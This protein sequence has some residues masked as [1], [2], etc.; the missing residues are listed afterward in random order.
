MRKT[1]LRLLMTVIAVVGF[2]F[3]GNAQYFTETFENGGTFPA[4]WTLTNG[5]DDWDIDQGDDY[6]PGAAQ[7]GTYCAFFNDYDYSSGTEAEMISPNIDLSTATAPL[8]K[9]W[10]WDDGGSDVVEVLASSDGSTYST[11]YTTDETVSDWTEITV[12][13]SAYAGQATVTISFKGT[14]VYGMTNPH[15]DNIIID[16]APSCPNPSAQA[17]SDILTT[18][19]TLSWTSGDAESA[20]NVEY[21]AIGFTQGT[22]TTVAVTDT[23][24]NI[25]GLTAQ[26][27][28]DFYVQADCGGS[29]VSTWVGPYTFTTLCDAYTATFS[30][31]FDGVTTPDL[32]ACWNSLI[33][34]PSTTYSS[35]T[36]STTQSSSADNSIKLY[37]SSATSS[38]NILLITPNFSD[39]TSQSNRIKFKAHMDGSGLE[40][41]TMTDL[42]DEST[43]TSYQTIAENAGVWTEYTIDFDGNY[44]DN[45]NYIVFRHSCENTYDNIYIDD[46]VYEP[47]PSCLEPSAQA[48]S[49]ILTTSA[50]LS[51][52]S[53]DAESAW[54]VEYGAAGYT[55]GTGTTVA[56][57][58]TFINITGLTAQTDYDFYVQADCGGDVSVWVGPYSFS[59]LCDVVSTFQYTEDF[60]DTSIP[61]CWDETRTPSSSYGWDSYTGGYDANCFRFDSYFNSNG[62]ISLLNTVTFDFSAETSLELKFW[63]KNPSGGNFKVVLSTDGGSTY[64]VTLADN[65]TG[66]SDY[67][68]KIIDLTAYC[69]GTNNNI[70]IGF[71][72]TSNY[73]SGDAYIYLDK[74][75]IS[76][77][78]TCPAP[79]AQDAIN[80]DG[81]SADLQWITGGS[82]LWNIVYG[83]Q[84]FDMNDS[85]VINV[86]DTIY[87]VSGLEPTTSYDFYVQD[88]CGL[89]DVSVWV[90]PYTFTTTVSCPAPTGLTATSITN[91][92]A[93]VSWITG[94]S[95]LWNIVY[96]PQGFDMNDSTAISV[97]DTFYNI[98]GL[99]PGTN[100]DFYVQDSCGVVDVSDWTG[101]YT[102]NTECDVVTTFPWIED[103]EENADELPICFN[104]VEGTWAMSTESYSGTY[105]ARIT[106]NHSNPAHLESPD[107]IL[108]ANHKIS[109][110][111][112]DD[113]V[114]LAKVIGHDTTF[115]EISTD[116]GANWI[117]LDT[118]SASSNESNYNMAEHDLSAYAGTFKFRFRDVSDAS[119]SA[120]GTGV[121]SIVI[122]ENDIIDLALIMPG[123]EDYSDCSFTGQ[124]TIP[125]FVEN[126]G[127]I[128]IAATDTIFAWYELD[129]AA[130]V[131]DTFIIATDINP[132]DTMF[133]FFAQTADL[134]GLTTHNFKVYFEYEPGTDMD[135]VN[136]T[137]VGTVTHY[138]LTVD[139]GGVNDTISTNSYPYTLDAGANLESYLWND[140]SMN[141][142]L[143]VNADGWYDV[144]VTDTNGCEAFD[145]VYVQLTIGINTID[146]ISLNIYPNP[147]NGEFTLNANFNTAIDFT[148]DIIN[149]NGKTIYSKEFNGVDTINESIDIDEYSKGVYYVRIVN[150]NFVKQEKVIVY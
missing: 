141:Q 127:N 142:T 16:E 128:V 135:Q 130:A 98:S 113:D 86:T 7:E 68:E 131:A 118:L 93:I 144:L 95:N 70:V 85:T 75:S 72:G 63:W 45:N 65:L 5:T 96:G 110:M 60:E 87:N 94:G 35:V 136:D 10:Y 143:D 26:T 125:F 104:N 49:D 106:W 25:T 27:D 30:E 17:V 46:F 40:I 18:S 44:T 129:G 23:F 149:L 3:Y 21:G 150:E 22:G 43:Y 31:N 11:V 147:N 126:V 4:G 124:D 78:P 115:F 67:E 6:G 41:G 47:I 62:N 132:T 71:E 122:R 101:P 112:K 103:F 15:V 121:D 19:A 69:G 20:W 80:I 53:G 73:G 14:S 90:G 55:Q 79:T 59:T 97:A 133:A 139:L 66:V 37:N 138:M 1:T 74:L 8:L 88:S 111:W 52:T 120:Y 114:T 99:A 82:N 58:D 89:G 102:F 123:N 34:T 140:G 145:S 9:F 117:T 39:L 107:F 134:A 42:T 116:D 91:N 105:A 84:G 32:P 109:F 48:V 33:N 2:T 54:N 137:T 146:G 51:W 12:D 100:Y 29:D 56:A 119:Y 28:Y 38:E 77:P 24:I 92:S 108:P 148:L 83:P 50:T 81:H 76:A 36:S 57:T 61:A 13:L 64:S